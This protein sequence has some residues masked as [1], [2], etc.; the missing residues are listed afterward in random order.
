MN[1]RLLSAIL[2]VAM[3]VSMFSMIFVNPVVGAAATDYENARENLRKAI[4]ELAMKGPVK[5]DQT[6]RTDMTAYKNGNTLFGI[7]TLNGTPIVDLASA[8]PDLIAS[9]RDDSV[10]VFSFL[11]RMGVIENKDG[12]DRKTREDFDGAIKSATYND[13]LKDFFVQ[14]PAKFTAAF[15][16]AYDIGNLLVDASIIYNISKNAYAD[17]DS[18]ISDPDKKVAHDETFNAARLNQVKIYT[19]KI[20]AVL[21]Y[22][23]DK[24]NN[25]SNKAHSIYFAEFTTYGN[26]YLNGYNAS[27]HKDFGVNPYYFYF[28]NIHSWSGDVNLYAKFF[29]VAP[30]W[31]TFDEIKANESW[32]AL[33]AAFDA[34]IMKAIGKYKNGGE[35]TELYFDFL[36]FGKAPKAAL[37]AL[38]K[39]LLEI[40]DKAAIVTIEDRK[41][42]AEAWLR[43]AAANQIFDTYINLN[44]VNK[45]ISSYLSSDEIWLLA[46][47]AKFLVDF[48]NGNPGQIH[49]LNKDTVNEL[50]DKLLKAIESFDIKD[51]ALSDGNMADAIAAIKGARY[52]LNSYKALEYVKKFDTFYKDLEDAVI[53]LET[54]TPDAKDAKKEI[55]I[56]LKSPDYLKITG[57]Y[58]SDTIETSGTAV[59]NIKI[60][61]YTLQAQIDNVTAKLLDFFNAVAIT[62]PNETDEDKYNKIISDNYYLAGMLNDVTAEVYNTYLVRT[63]R[64]FTLI[65]LPTTNADGVGGY[66]A[67]NQIDYK[68]DALAY[69]GTGVNLQGVVDSYSK[70]V[71]AGATPE[72][73]P[74][75]YAFYN[76]ALFA[77][78]MK[79]SHTTVSYDGGANKVTIAVKGYVNS[80]SVGTARNLIKVLINDIHVEVEKAQYILDDLN[81]DANN[82]VALVSIFELVGTKYEIR[83]N[84]E[85]MKKEY[86]LKGDVDTIEAKYNAY[87]NIL[88]DYQKNVSSFNVSSS[89]TW[90]K[91]SEAK[92]A[93]DE[94]MKVNFLSAEGYANYERYLAKIDAVA[95]D[96]YKTNGRYE[97]IWHQLQ[98]A[99]VHYVA[100]VP[101]LGAIGGEFNYNYKMS[102]FASKGYLV[103]GFDLL[104]S[105]FINHKYY[106]NFEQDNLAGSDGLQLD[107]VNRPNTNAAGKSIYTTNVYS[108]SNSSVATLK[109]LGGLS[110]Q[111]TDY[112]GWDDFT[113]VRIDNVGYTR[114]NKNYVEPLTKLINDLA[115]MISDAAKENGFSRTSVANAKSVLGSARTLKNNIYFEKSVEYTVWKHDADFFASPSKTMNDYCWNDAVLLT[116]VSY[117]AAELALMPTFDSGAGTWANQTSTVGPKITMNVKGFIFESDSDILGDANTSANGLNKISLNQAEKMISDLKAAIDKLNDNKVAD[118]RKYK[119]A[120]LVPLLNQAAEIKASDYIV[121]IVDGFDTI[122]KN[123][124][125]YYGEGVACNVDIRADRDEINGVIDRLKGAMKAVEA[126]AKNP[127]PAPSD[128][129]EVQGLIDEGDKIV[130]RGFAGSKINAL[131][132]VLVSAKKAVVIYNET[133]NGTQLG[134]VKLDLVAAIADAEEE[135]LDL[136]KDYEAAIAEAKLVDTSLYTDVTVRPFLGAIVGAENSLKAKASKSEIIEKIKRMQDLQ[137][138]LVL[139]PVVVDDKSTT[140]KEAIA[141]YDDMMAEVAALDSDTV[142]ADSL[143]ALNAALAEL[144]AAIDA[145]AED[146][147]LVSLIINVKL[148]RAALVVK[149]PITSDFE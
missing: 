97:E 93:F 116:G 41:A 148:A 69:P 22:L 20:N 31:F 87:Y 50:A 142:T 63:M 141:I 83:T 115:D 45:F 122:W 48:G 108:I 36:N 136:I 53:A 92:K 102:M 107:W 59:V 12:A 33:L 103:G 2:A 10:N 105:W 37:E 119:D 132:D 111:K 86:F 70:G 71:L 112:H 137:K 13:M 125:N 9:N 7:S 117:T 110:F 99:D 21:N 114:L 68:H 98:L 149:A 18:L 127:I 28:A 100:F 55:K 133:K 24:A 25:T 8:F 1:K 72:A 46:A 60:N 90:V 88:K 131:K 145:G 104:N 61:K 75:L 147:V 91:V 135:I 67:N 52:T 121:G 19:D 42:T 82:I 134:Q 15:G 17:Y 113:S 6:I 123:F 32:A 38:C 78:E 26:Y 89:A 27:Y 146:D 64:L 29:G 139:I 30:K 143:A 73:E 14:D 47:Q 128:I 65:N 44:N 3:V 101:A 85:S 40:N 43:L 94:A 80:D 79:N 16:D 76:Y 35:N 124:T 56:T 81:G 51:A 106:V 62:N 74:K 34:E 5:A 144:K 120:N 130:A 57:L 4:W 49:A 39:A 66:V 84:V 126:I 95:I 77:R 11:V 58:S 118:L 138:A 23:K 129:E 54:V 109:S 96:W 140:M